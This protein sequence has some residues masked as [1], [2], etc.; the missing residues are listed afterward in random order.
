LICHWPTTTPLQEID[1]AKIQVL[2]VPMNV[3]VRYQAQMSKAIWRPSSARKLGFLVVHEDALLGLIALT[4]PVIRL[5]V[6]DN[7]LFPGAPDGFKYGWALR[8]YMDMSVCVG[9]QPLAWHWHLGKLMA[10]IAPTLGDYVEA[11]SP[12]DKFKGVTTTS[13]YGGQKATQ[14]D[15]VYKYLGETAGYGSEQVN[16]EEYKLMVCVLKACHALPSCNWVAGSNARM[17][18]IAA[19]R[20]LT[21][22]RTATLFHGHKRGVYYHP[23]VPPEQRS[24]VI[25]NWYARRGLPRYI[26]TKNDLAPYQNGLDGRAA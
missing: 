26:K 9:A 12:K 21:G 16:D 19:Y 11:R 2:P 4:S 17:R 24:A 25:Q 3:M 13:L 1:P 15:G 5:T 18:K 6:R 23:A 14:Y 22:D 10:M 7:F 20:K 8:S